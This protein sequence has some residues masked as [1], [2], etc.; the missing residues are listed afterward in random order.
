MR[1]DWEGVLNPFV[2]LDRLNDVANGEREGM[3]DLAAIY[4]Q[5]MSDHLSKL[6]AAIRNGKCE[7][8]EHIAHKAAGA[9]AM[10]GM[11]AVV[12]LLRELETQSGQ[13][14]LAQ[15]GELLGKIRQTFSDICNF[16]KSEQLVEK[17]SVP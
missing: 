7:D 3:Q 8:I 1:A 9:S 11:D 16:L 2:D 5:T 10:V 15:G 14:N 13:K 4:I 6:D 17:G 12:P